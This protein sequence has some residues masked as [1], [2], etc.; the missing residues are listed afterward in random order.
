LGD[1]EKRETN[2]P[3]EFAKS[4]FSP[5]SGIPAKLVPV[6]FKPGAGIQFLQDVLDPGACPGIDPGFA[7]VTI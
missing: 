7:G 2:N 4:R 3:D 5:E 6:G 1:W